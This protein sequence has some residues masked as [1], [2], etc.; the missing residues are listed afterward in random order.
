[1]LSHV[2]TDADL[3]CVGMGLEL[4]GNS[5]LGAGREMG[6]GTEEQLRSPCKEP[7]EGSRPG[8][9]HEPKCSRN[10]LLL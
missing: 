8:N 3:G 6:A 5:W 2:P 9:P 1:M 4:E 7:G 10:Q